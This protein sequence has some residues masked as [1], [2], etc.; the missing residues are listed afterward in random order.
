MQIS[1]RLKET[2]QHDTRAV[3]VKDKWSSLS[4]IY[5]GTSLIRTPL[6]QKKVS[7]LARCPDFG[8]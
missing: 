7:R 2:K 1:E 8:G 4:R 3:A 5:S 6:G